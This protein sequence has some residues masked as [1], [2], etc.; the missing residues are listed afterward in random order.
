MFGRI[1]LLGISLAAFALLG[2]AG[3]EADSDRDNDHDQALE[4]YEHGDI[5]SLADII[6]ALHKKVG[7]QVVDVTLDHAGDQWTYWLT[8][9][10]DAGQRVRVA[11]DARSMAIS[12]G[13]ED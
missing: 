8:V 12:Q 6:R 1:R 13:G 2:V 10:T 3:A 7:G 5:R 9:I 4:L 11:V